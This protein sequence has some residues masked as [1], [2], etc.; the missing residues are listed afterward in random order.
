MGAAEPG[1]E[2]VG[3]T[4]LSAWVIGWRCL[5]VFQPVSCVSAALVVALAALGESARSE[6]CV[7]RVTLML[8]ARAQSTLR[9]CQSST[10]RTC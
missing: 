2:G 7:E 3:L 1:A 6:R 9:R 10:P 8:R 4:C 5:F